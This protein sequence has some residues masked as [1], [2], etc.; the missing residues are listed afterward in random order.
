MGPD[1]FNNLEGSF[2]VI[3]QR[4]WPKPERHTENQAWLAI[5]PH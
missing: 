2:G 4:T 3:E 5:L 1:A